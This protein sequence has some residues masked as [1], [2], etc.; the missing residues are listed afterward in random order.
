MLDAPPYIRP[1]MLTSHP[2]IHLSLIGCIPIKQLETVR[3]SFQMSL[4]T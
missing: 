4:L 1:Y 2:N 3:L